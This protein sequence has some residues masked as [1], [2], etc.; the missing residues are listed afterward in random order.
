MKYKLMIKTQS[1]TKLKYLCITKT[2]KYKKYTGF[3]KRWLAHL[4]KHGRDFTTEVIYES[5]DYL[6]FVEKCIYYSELF[7]VVNNSDFANLIPESGY[8]GSWFHYATNEMRKN[9]VLKASETRKK[10]KAEFPE[11]Y[12]KSAKQRWER[13][14]LEI[15]QKFED[16]RRKGLEKFFKNR[17]S[18]EFLSW[19]EKL[20]VAQKERISKIP[21]EILSERNRKHRLSMSDEKKEMRREKFKL[22]KERGCYDA[23]IKRMKEERKGTNNPY[24]RVITWMGTEYTFSQFKSLN[25]PKR[26]IS[27]KMNVWE[28]C[29]DSGS[30]IQDKPFVVCPHCNKC[31]KATSSF[32][33]WHFDNCKNKP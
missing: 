29:H 12:S 18:D 32:K 24:A 9:A 11:Y 6:E 15:R 28:N 27:E 21:F 5:D 4:K 19:R 7:D 23:N 14:S 25:I 31:G 1:N 22:A 8:N 33:R 3:G 17:D 10:K 30:R 2:E 20:S 13:T 26:E 16:A